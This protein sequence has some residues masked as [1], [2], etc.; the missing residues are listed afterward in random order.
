MPT[1]VSSPEFVG[2]AAEL[3]RL[4]AAL[5]RA[6]G[7][8]AAAV[9]VAGESGVGKTRLLRELERRAAARGARV[10]RG[11]CLAFGADGLPYAPIAAALRGLARELEPGVFEELVGAGAAATS[12]GCCRS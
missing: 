4:E 6:E 7:G 5:D 2:R 10:L 1:R 12:R 11:D 8:T 9:F 3:G